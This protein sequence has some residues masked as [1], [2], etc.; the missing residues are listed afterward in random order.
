MSS[1]SRSFLS[2]LLGLL[3]FPSVGVLYLA[4]AM[5]FLILR[6]LLLLCV[7]SVSFLR[8]VIPPGFSTL[9]SMR[10]QTRVF[11]PPGWTLVYLAA[12]LAHIVSHLCILVLYL[13]LRGAAMPRLSRTARIFLT[14][15]VVRIRSLGWV[16]V[17]QVLPSGSAIVRDG[18]GADWLVTRG[19]IDPPDDGG[20][21]DEEGWAV[22][23]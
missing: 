1:G 21:D 18:E 19:L 5:A 10:G 11:L 3:L 20:R 23:L 17:V 12:P 4:L 22:R 9:S 15:S 7:M 13:V 6:S 2:S 8:A 16:T 14:G